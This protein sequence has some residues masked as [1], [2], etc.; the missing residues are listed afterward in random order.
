MGERVG[1]STV[2][3][4]AKCKRCGVHPSRGPTPTCTWTRRS[5]MPAGPERS[6]VSALVAYA[7]G[8]DGH[9]RLLGITLGPEESE[10]SWS[11]LLEQLLERGLSG[12]QL[13]IADEHAGLEPRCAASCPRCAASADCLQRTCWPRQRRSVFRQ[14]PAGRRAHE[15]IFK[16]FERLHT[17]QEFA[18]SGL[19]LATAERM[20]RI[21]RRH[22]GQVWG[23][24]V[25][26]DG[27]VF[28]FTLGS[29]STGE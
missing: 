2:S 7:V 5:S 17:R 18:G 12:V 27:A 9:R 28:R 22:G 15:I 20:E 19:G 3:R 25:L 29:S 14:A 24:G 6:R 21:V 13:V 4:V 8:P 11:E 10:N 23:E 16:A 1:R 26:G